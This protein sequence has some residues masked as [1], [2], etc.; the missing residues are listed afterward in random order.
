M[1]RNPNFCEKQMHISKLSLQCNTLVVK[2]K[3]M[4][5]TVLRITCREQLHLKSSD[6]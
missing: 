2:A 6:L 1:Q 3:E 4:E 5:K